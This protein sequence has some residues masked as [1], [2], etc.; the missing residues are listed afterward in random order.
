[1]P[2][3]NILANIPI[4]KVDEFQLGGAFKV[5]KGIF[6]QKQRRQVGSEGLG[7]KCILLH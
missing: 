6:N 5:Y 7:D 3:P 4:E 2:R 1:M